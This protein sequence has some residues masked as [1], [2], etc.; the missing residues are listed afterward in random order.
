M[1]TVYVPGAAGP[2]VC[3]DEKVCAGGY[4]AEGVFHRGIVTCNG[5]PRGPLHDY[6]DSGSGADEQRW[7][8]R[9]QIIHKR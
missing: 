6:G 8:L 3:N 2:W 1:T 5:V 4:R 7:R 9:R